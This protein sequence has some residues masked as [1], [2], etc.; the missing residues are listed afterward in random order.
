MKNEH[1][2]IIFLKKFTEEIIDI[3]IKQ[4]AAE[5]YIKIEKFKQ[6]FLEEKP[7][8]DEAFKKAVKT[9]VFKPSLFT[10]RI[11]PQQDI[12]QPTTGPS[13]R[14]IEKE[15]ATHPKS[16][17]FVRSMQSGE[18]EKAPVRPP[19][20]RLRK[21]LQVK[22]AATERAPG[23][24]LGKIQQ[25]LKDPGVQLLE[26]PGPGK[27]I[28]VKKLN[29]MNVTKITMNKEE[30]NEVINSFS[31]EARIPLIGGILKAAVGDLIISAVVSE[32]VG[33]R[34]IINKITPFNLVDTS[35]I[36]KI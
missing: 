12:P 10:K 5:H 34:F 9:P 24:A 6:E 22:P 33:S 23:L 20:P 8:P 14:P 4:Y 28:L 3:L 7:T 29:K 32:F 35:E 31:R 18:K 15:H 17:Q 21:M 2:R 13:I 19:S 16:N 26:C 25:L 30:I 11:I 36:P 1:L 27:N